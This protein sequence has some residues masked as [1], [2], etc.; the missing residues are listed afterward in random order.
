MDDFWNQVEIKTLDECWPWLGEYADEGYGIYGE[1]PRWG[2]AH[3]VAFRKHYG[4]EAKV[5]RHICD[6]KWCCN[7]HHMLDGNKLDNRRDMLLPPCRECR[8][9]GAWMLPIELVNEEPQIVGTKSQRMEAEVV[10]LLRKHKSKGRNRLTYKQIAAETGLSRNTI[11][12][13]RKRMQEGTLQKRRV[14]VRAPVVV[15]EPQGYSRRGAHEISPGVYR[16]PWD[17]QW[18]HII[19]LESELR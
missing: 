7:P 14:R 15:P 11:D 8:R 17:N 3:R 1:H 6:H 19:V 4:F 5:C 10:A 13:I 2:N 18:G 12:V 9:Y 16:V